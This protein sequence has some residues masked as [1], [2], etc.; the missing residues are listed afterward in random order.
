MKNL[1]Y[2]SENHASN[3]GIYC[4]RLKRPFFKNASAEM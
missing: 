3:L 2:I 1:V 4:N